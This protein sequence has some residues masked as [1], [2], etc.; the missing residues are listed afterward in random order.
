MAESETHSL[1]VSTYNLNGLNQGRWL[2]EL[3]CS[4]NDCVFVQEHWLAPFDLHCLYDLC[5]DTI[6]FAS[7]A[8]DT[9]ISRGCLHGRPFGGVAIFVKKSLGGITRLVKSSSRYII[10]QVG[11][12]ILI[13]VYL[14]SVGTT[15][16]VEELIDCLTSI[17]NDV[18]DLQYSFVI[19]GGDMNTDLSGDTEVCAVVQNFAEELGLKFVTDKLPTD[20]R[21]TYRVETTGA[22]STIDHFAVTQSLYT[23]VQAVK[24]FDSGINLSDH[25][26]LILNVNLPGI[27]KLPTHAK[28]SE[29]HRE[30]NLF[31][32]GTWAMLCSI[33]N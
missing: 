5:D 16:R 15:N 7:S 18:V 21:T 9:A 20:D 8:M 30:H 23:S 11:Q 10:V 14:P 31:I 13:N 2:L 25:C 6:C 28:G 29:K 24:V 26:P 33:T 27:M 17:I 19:F 1:S 3:L 32:A 22:E 4:K 12:V